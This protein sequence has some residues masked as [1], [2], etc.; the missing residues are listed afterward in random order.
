MEMKVELREGEESE[1]RITDNVWAKM[2]IN[3]G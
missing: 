3:G 1:T 2:E